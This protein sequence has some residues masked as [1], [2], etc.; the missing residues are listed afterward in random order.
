MLQ[1]KDCAVPGKIIGKEEYFIIG[2]SLSRDFHVQLLLL[3]N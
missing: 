3:G 1:D 2:I